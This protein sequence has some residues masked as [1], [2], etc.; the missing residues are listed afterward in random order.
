MGLLSAKVLFWKK[1][2]KKLAGQL[3]DF[4]ATGK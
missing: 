3:A 2:G 4:D 1:W